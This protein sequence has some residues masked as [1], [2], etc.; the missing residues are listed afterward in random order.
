MRLY[1]VFFL[2]GSRYWESSG[3]VHKS[4]VRLGLFGWDWCGG[5]GPVVNK[6]G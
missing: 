3:D 5:T 4:F 2:A 6:S 1:E